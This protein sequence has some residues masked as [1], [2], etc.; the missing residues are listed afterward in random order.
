MTLP[1]VH[2]QEDTRGVSM[3]V[4]LDKVE[5]YLPLRLRS[6]LEPLMLQAQLKIMV[7]LPS[8]TRGIH[9]SRIV[10]CVND[11]SATDKRPLRKLTERLCKKLETKEARVEATF[12]YPWGVDRSPITGI[13]APMS[14]EAGVY[15]AC[16]LGSYV[17]AVKVKVPVMTVCPCSLALTGGKGAHVQRAYVQATL[18]ADSHKVVWIEDVADALA[19]SGSASI[20]NILKRLDEKA[21]VEEAFDNPKFAEDVIRDAVLALRDLSEISH[22]TVEVISQESIHPFDVVAKAHF[23]R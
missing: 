16:A 6:G 22:G 5:A 12:T 14:C 17:E 10:E 23:D 15:G 13:S 1:D 21:V 3:L 4:G 7:R 18:W 20:H 11:I 2:T 19:V 9:M 8:R